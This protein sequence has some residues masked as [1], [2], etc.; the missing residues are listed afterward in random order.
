MGRW[1]SWRLGAV[2]HTYIHINMY[3]SFHS[4]YISSSSAGRTK[5]SRP[6]PKKKK[7]TAAAAAAHRH[8][9]TTAPRRRNTKRAAKQKRAGLPCVFVSDEPLFP[10]WCSCWALLW[11]YWASILPLVLFFLCVAGRCCFL[12]GAEEKSISSC[13]LVVWVLVFGCCFWLAVVK[14]PNKCY[15]NNNHTVPTITP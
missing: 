13:L 14:W 10:F 15:D 1:S 9:I 12:V 7:E 11:L 4:I 2:H 3:V 8:H 5:G 6:T